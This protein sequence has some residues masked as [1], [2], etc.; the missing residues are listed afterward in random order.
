MIYE[1]E[2]EEKE[3]EAAARRPGLTGRRRNPFSANLFNSPKSKANKNQFPAVF[4]RFLF[5]VQP[6][7][8]QLAL[9]IN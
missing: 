3:K 6:F 4:F 8:F 9:K 5:S 2:E 7:A 1:A